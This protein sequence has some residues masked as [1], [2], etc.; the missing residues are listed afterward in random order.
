MR[1]ICFS[2]D[3]QQTKLDLKISGINNVAPYKKARQYLSQ[4]AIVNQVNLIQLTS[5]EV[6]FQLDIVGTVAALQ[7]AIKLDHV[8]TPSGYALDLAALHNNTQPSTDT[9][10]AAANLTL[11]YKWT[12]SLNYL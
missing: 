4:L 9:S 6:I 11:A 12:A 3:A 5:N 1:A 2:G 7:R 10:A 8:L